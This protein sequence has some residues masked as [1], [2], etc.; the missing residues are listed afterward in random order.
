VILRGCDFCFNNFLIFP[1]RIP[2]RTYPDV[3]AA[4][5]KNAK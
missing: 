5:R 2:A 3:A 1:G 4:D